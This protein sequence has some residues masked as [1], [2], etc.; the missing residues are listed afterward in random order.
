[1][2]SFTEKSFSF[3][4]DGILNHF[5]HSGLNKKEK[6]N[7][8]TIF[9]HLTV[10]CNTVGEQ[11]RLGYHKSTQIGRPGSHPLH[12]VFSIIVVKLYSTVYIVHLHHPYIESLTDS[13]IQNC[14][15][16]CYWP[17]PFLA[18]VYHYNT[19]EQKDGKKTGK[20]WEHATC[21]AM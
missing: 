1:M 12:K 2:N 6:D 3:Y 11:Y 13:L 20:V 14:C 17:P 5:Q 10:F 8:V 4:N 21:D 19:Q 15:I 9:L 7:F 16:L 18:S